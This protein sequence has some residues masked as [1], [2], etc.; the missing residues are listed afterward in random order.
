VRAAAGT[1]HVIGVQWVLFVIITGRGLAW[2]SSAAQMTG[3]QHAR[4][5]VFHLCSVLAFAQA[6]AVV[7][8]LCRYLAA[9]R[10]DAGRTLAAVR[11]M[12]VA[13]VV[14]MVMS[15]RVVRRS[16]ASVCFTSLGNWFSLGAALNLLQAF[17][18]FLKNRAGALLYHIRRT[19][20]PVYTKVLIT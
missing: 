16:Q 11:F 1:S 2:A 20:K 9:A 15:V 13:A 8:L 18:F 4:A 7:P 17:F 12:F 10:R 3:E 19:R 14:L 5:V 6:V